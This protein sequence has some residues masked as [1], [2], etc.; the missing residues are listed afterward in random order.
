MATQIGHFI[1]GSVTHT[2]AYPRQW[3]EVDLGRQ[4]E[5]SSVPLYN[6]V[7]CCQDRLTNFEVQIV[8]N[9]SKNNYYIIYFNIYA[10]N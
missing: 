6:R 3:W 1:A 2:N 10:V 4:S 9:D 5:I 8:L 7:D